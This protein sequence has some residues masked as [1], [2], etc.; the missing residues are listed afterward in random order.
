MTGLPNE[1]FDIVLQ[2]IPSKTLYQCLYVS[3]FWYL[4]ASRVYYD[5]NSIVFE[6]NHRTVY[7]NL[8]RAR[9]D[10]RQ[11]SSYAREYRFMG[12][13][14]GSPQET[15]SR[16]NFKLLI[17]ICSPSLQRIRLER[18]TSSIK[19]AK[20]LKE[21]PGDDLLKITLIDTTEDDEAFPYFENLASIIMRNRQK[22]FAK[23]DNLIFEVCCGLNK[24]ISSLRMRGKS[25]FSQKK[26]VSTVQALWSFTKLEDLLIEDAELTNLWKPILSGCKELRKFTFNARTNMAFRDSLFDGY[27]ETDEPVMNQYLESFE[28]AVHRLS[29]DEVNYILRYVP[30]TLKRFSLSMKSLTLQAWVAVLNENTMPRLLNHIR[31]AEMVCFQFYYRANEPMMLRRYTIW[32]LIAN[33]KEQDYE[34]ILNVDFIDID[35]PADNITDFTQEKL[36]VDR[37]KKKIQV[38]LVCYLRYI[39]QW[40]VDA[41][42][43]IVNQMYGTVFYTTTS[44]GYVKQYK[45]LINSYLTPEQLTNVRYIEI[46]SRFRR[47]SRRRANH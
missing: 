23:L 4:S 13:L 2:Q 17:R 38:K 26:M 27:I 24:S 44:E 12:T 10:G 35:I 29:Q 39:Q 37:N 42:L 25:Y 36:S 8:I 9:L 41:N 40:I 20:Y 1:L 32:D 21:I 18:N 30:N 31:Q 7:E 15:I 43:S 33:L 22:G 11:V 46:Q 3:K 19:Y 34:V 28:L 47:T 45:A 14:D 5:K 6:N 16:E